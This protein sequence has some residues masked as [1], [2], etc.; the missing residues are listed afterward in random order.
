MKTE[1]ATSEVSVAV[2]ATLQRLREERGLS[3]RTLAGRAGFSPSFLSQVENGQSSP[4][5][6]SLG[7]LARCLGLG[8]ADFF[9]QAEEGG[10]PD[11]RHPPLVAHSASRRN[12]TS[13]WSRAEIE[14]LVP[15]GALRELEGF[16]VTLVPG[17]RSGKEPTGEPVE[18]LALVLEG[19]IALT[20]GDDEHRLGAGDAAAIPAGASHLW[21]NPGNRPAR[22]VLL[23]SRGAASKARPSSPP[24]QEEPAS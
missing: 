16:L 5:I 24:E 13:A 7:T 2:G 1:A 15:R 3:L 17:G 21:T 14:P 19:E 8:L 22:M 23:R 11:R 18:Q 4:S 20:L 9:G 12:L 10:P 6:A